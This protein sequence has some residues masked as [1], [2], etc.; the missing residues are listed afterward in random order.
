MTDVLTRLLLALSKDPAL[1]YQLWKRMRT[2]RFHGPWEADGGGRFVLVTEDE[3]EVA[4]VERNGNCWSWSVVNGG[5][6]EAWTV[7]EAKGKVEA[8]L[9]ADGWRMVPEGEWVPTPHLARPRD[10]VGPWTHNVG[11]DTW[12][13]FYTSGD[14]SASIERRS[15]PGTFRWATWE[16]DRTQA[17]IIENGAESTVEWAKYR[18]DQYLLNRGLITRAQATELHT[19]ENSGGRSP[20]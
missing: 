5:G 10:G 6:G 20:P 19:A 11:K 17:R 14:I 7:E 16:E 3:V 12:S 9:Q 18:A 15:T 1:E 8:E 13:R 2:L 4:D